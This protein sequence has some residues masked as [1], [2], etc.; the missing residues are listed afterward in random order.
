MIFIKLPRIEQQAISKFSLLSSN[1]MSKITLSHWK[2]RVRV[3]REPPVSIPIAYI[4]NFHTSNL[5]NIF[6]IA[7]VRLVLLRNLSV[8]YLYWLGIGTVLYVRRFFFSSSL[9][10]QWYDTVDLASVRPS[11]ISVI[12]SINLLFGLLS[13]WFLCYYATL[14][15]K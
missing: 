7:I 1:T 11:F 15:G 5:I 3:N 2:Q 14:V 6:R 4:G 9:T 8:P 13:L 12:E 10:S